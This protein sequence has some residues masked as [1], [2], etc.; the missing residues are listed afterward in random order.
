[1]GGDLQWPIRRQQL[2]RIGESV[3]A[4]RRGSGRPHKG[5]D[6]FARA[7]TPV[8]PAASGIVT[9]V[10]DGRESKD[11]SLHRAGLFVEIVDDSGRLHRYLHLGSVSVREGAKASLGNP[12]GKVGAIGA[13]G[14]EHSRPHVHYELRADVPQSGYGT[15]IDPLTVLPSLYPERDGVA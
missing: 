2:R 13:S 5:I 15:P 7:D 9:A 3:T 8:Y 11:E 12:I 6:L 14:V 10:V 1:M 4:H